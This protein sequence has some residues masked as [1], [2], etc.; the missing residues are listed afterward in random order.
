MNILSRGIETILSGQAF[1]NKSSL[2]DE[3]YAM[4]FAKAITPTQFGKIGFNALLLDQ[5]PIIGENFTPTRAFYH[6]GGGTGYNHCFMIVPEHQLVI[7]VLSNSI[8]HGDIADWTA[9]TIFQA[10]LDIKSPVDLKP[11]AR[12]AAATWRATCQKMADTLEKERIP[13]TQKPLYEDLI[14]TFYHP[15]R[16]V[17]IKVFETNGQLK[18]NLNGRSDQEHVLSHYHHDTFIFLPSAEER[19]RRVLFHYGPQAWLLHFK[20]DE[21]CKVVNV[22]WNLDPE[23]PAGEIL[24]RDTIENQTGKIL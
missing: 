13:N 3:L 11:M 20:K 18:F 5:M 16:A 15:T 12:Q 24:G 17:Y 8:S 14:G 19:I 6:S 21:N 23:S 9:Q 10:A 2:S 4:G 7:V 22:V 1:I